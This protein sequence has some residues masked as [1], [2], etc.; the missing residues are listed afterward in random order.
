VN[1][2][3]IRP[4]VW[5]GTCKKDLAEFPEAVRDGIG[6]ALYVAQRGGKHPDAKPLRGFTGAGVLEIVE[7]YDGDTYR[8]VYTVR[9]AGRIYALHAFQKTAKSGIKTPKAEIDLIR[10]RL[11]RAEQ[12]HAA[13]R[14]RQR[15]E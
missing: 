7:S 12:E 1:T 13:S 8:A 9:M 3:S 2:G 14:R 6:Y 15:E 5:I 10:A 4:I 11:V